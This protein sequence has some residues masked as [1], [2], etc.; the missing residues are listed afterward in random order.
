M[1]S[2]VD[3][4]N[5][6]PPPFPKTIRDEILN[7]TDNKDHKTFIKVLDSPT[8]NKLF[9]GAKNVSKSF[10]VMIDTIYRIVNEPDYCAVWARNL[11][12]DIQNTI[13]PCFIKALDFLKVVHNIDLTPF[14]DIYAKVVVYK[15]TQQAIFFANFE[16]VN[17]FAGLTLKKTNFDICDVVFDEIQQNP[18][19][20]GNQLEKIYSKQP[21]DMNFI[22]QSTILRTK[23]KPNQKRRMIFLFN[24]YDSKHWVCLKYVIP[25]LP[26]NLENRKKLVDQSYLYAESNELDCSIM[27][28]SRFYVPKSEIDEFQMREYED[29]KIENPKLYDITVAG[30]PYDNQSSNIIFPFIDFIYDDNNQINSNLIFNEEINNYKFLLIVDGL[31]PGLKDNNGFCRIGVTENYE[32]VVIYA[33]EIKSSEFSNFKRFTSLE[34]ILSLICSL[35]EFMNLE[36]SILAI[37]SKEDALIEMATKYIAEHN[38]NIMPIKAIKN[39]NPNF[40]IDFNISNRFSFFKQCFERQIIKFTPQSIKLIEYFA[41]QA[42][43][44]DGKR[45]EKINPKIYDLINAMEYATSIIYQLIILNNI[46]ENNND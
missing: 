34:Y 30:E 31:D 5:Q 36:N 14:F 42:F 16:L 6:I 10:G 41:Q 27:R 38:L 25:L 15:P 26:F 7:Y 40:Q 33:E 2:N 28:M 32:I 37:D 24:I 1:K 44:S 17:S 11:S 29:L 12:I 13:H 39:K 9:M 19:E 35:N 3:L 23:R 21:S 43:N 46:M 20:L 4:I 45:D 8:T 18:D 22:K